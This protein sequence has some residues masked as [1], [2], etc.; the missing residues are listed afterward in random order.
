MPLV[1]AASSGTRR[2]LLVVGIAASFVAACRSLFEPSLPVGAEEMTPPAV[3]ARWWSLVE[4][5]SNRSGSVYA[6]RWY[7]TPGSSFALKGQPEAGL[8]MSRGNRIVIAGGE[9]SDGALV[10]HEIL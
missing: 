2:V 9:V 8:W 3:Y 10:R 7:R 5:C 4:A 6:V 1:F